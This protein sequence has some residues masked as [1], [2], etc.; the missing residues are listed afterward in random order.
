MQMRSIMLASIA[1][2]LAHENAMVWHEA[3]RVDPEFRREG[4]AQSESHI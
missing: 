4:G 2:T 1:C 3:S